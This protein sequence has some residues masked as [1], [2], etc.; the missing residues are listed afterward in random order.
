MPTNKKEYMRRYFR[1][2]VKNSVVIICETCNG[3]YRRYNR[4]IHILCM[5]HINA[6]KNKRKK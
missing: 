5:K 6:E 2:Y 3:K 1:D 4:H